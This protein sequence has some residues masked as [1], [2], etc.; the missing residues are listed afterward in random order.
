[1]G[2]ATQELQGV[3]TNPIDYL[4]NEGEAT[5]YVYLGIKTKDSADGMRKIH[6]ATKLFA[7][8]SKH[9]QMLKNAHLF[10]GGLFNGMYNK[11]IILHD[12]SLPAH[13]EKQPKKEVRGLSPTQKSKVNAMME[14]GKGENDEGLKA[15]G[16][17]LN[18]SFDRLKAY[19]KS[20]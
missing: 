20:F 19:I 10:G 15:I 12:P 2:Q 7:P 8:P 13:V 5:G 9:H 11:M 16:K 17:E 14:E 4:I 6:G 3:V 1:M 18:I